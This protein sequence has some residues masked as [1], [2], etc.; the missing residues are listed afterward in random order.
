MRIASTA[1]TSVANA[2][3]DAID[4]MF[5]ELR[6]TGS[7]HGGR[8]AQ[9]TLEVWAP[10]GGEA[11]LTDGRMTY[12]HDPGTIERWYHTAPWLV[13]DGVDPDAALADA[14]RGVQ[15]LLAAFGGDLSTTL[16]KYRVASVSRP[17]RNPD[18]V[19]LW[20]RRDSGAKERYIIPVFDDC[21]PV[22]RALGVADRLAAV[23]R[24]RFDELD[25]LLLG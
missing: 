15:E 25:P 18:Q 1:V 8:Y 19:D 22:S 21:A 7:A 3:V 6:G 9:T 17:D 11:R 16:A 4:W 2:P 10:N 12:P 24:A 20:I 23:I 5:F 13:R 14:R